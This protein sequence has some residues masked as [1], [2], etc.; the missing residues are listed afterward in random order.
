[1]LTLVALMA[2]GAQVVA[3]ANCPIN[4]PQP[5]AERSR[6]GPQRLT[7]LP[8]PSLERTVLKSVAGCPIALV[9]DDDGRW[10][11]RAVHRGRLQGLRPR[12]AGE[13]PRRR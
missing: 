11:E 13:L 3:P 4:T 6:S 9:R 1:M 2:A 5:T 10:V 7:E 8:V 12:P